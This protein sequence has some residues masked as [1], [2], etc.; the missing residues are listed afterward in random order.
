MPI[1]TLGLFRKIF[2]LDF[3]AEVG[4]AI[5]LKVGDYN[6]M[7]PVPNGFPTCNDYMAATNEQQ[8]SSSLRILS[9]FELTLLCSIFVGI[10]R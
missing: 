10:L 7:P 8:K 9:V 1:S 4:M 5:I 2:Y 6:Q 3:H